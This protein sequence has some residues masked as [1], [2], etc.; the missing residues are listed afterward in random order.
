MRTT[1][2]IEEETHGYLS[3]YA[4]ARG[5]TLGEAIDELIRKAKA[6][7]QVPAP[8][9]GYTAS[10]FPVFPDSGG[11]VTDELVKKLAEDEFAPEAFA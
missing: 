2:S 3:Y 10:G 6:A 11:A 9:I 4:Q 5:I 7:P 8:E 1:V